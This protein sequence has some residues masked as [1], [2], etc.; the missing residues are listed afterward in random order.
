MSRPSDTEARR[1]GRP[2]QFDRDNALTA[3]CLL[4]WNR[5]YDAATQE[6]MLAA[7]GLSSSSLYRTF[8]TKSDILEAALTRYLAWADEMFA[9]LEHGSQGVAD[10]QAFFDRFQAQFDG[11]L[12]NAGCLVWNTMQNSIN[13]DSRIKTL[14]EQHMRRLR[15]GLTTAL[16]RAADAGELPPS[17]P[18]YLADVL[19]AGI[20]GVQARGRAGDTADAVRM[21]DG[22]RALLSAGEH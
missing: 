11:P 20:L 15:Q 17:A 19:R 22:L 5:G 9:P 16:Q 12:S 14:T 10:V 6:E 21:L 1:P 4:L 2:A 13:G 18:Q 3:L 8:G 7:T